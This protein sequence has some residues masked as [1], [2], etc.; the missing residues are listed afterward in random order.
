[1]NKLPMSEIQRT[2][3][4]SERKIEQPQDLFP[5][6]PPVRKENNEVKHFE[7][8]ERQTQTSGS[9]LGAFAN[10]SNLFLDRHALRIGRTAGWTD[11]GW[12]GSS[13]GGSLVGHALLAGFFFGVAGAG[14]D[15]GVEDVAA[16]AGETLEVVDDVCRGQVGGC[17]AGFGLGALLLPA[18]IEQLD[19][20]VLVEFGHG[21]LLVAVGAEGCWAGLVE[22]AGLRARH[23]VGAD[24][25]R[26]LAWGG[27][28]GGLGC[29]GLVAGLGAFADA[30][31]FFLLGGVGGRSGGDRL[32][33]VRCNH[34]RY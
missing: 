9:L 25:H 31:L 13:A 23:V 2:P 16:L 10:V 22:T 21:D 17:A 18:G 7:L 11:H 34:W 12:R 30:L 15:G 8:E 33:W 20:H 26:L 6:E 32:L 14:E 29:G 4:K 1:M 19:S 24:T 27:F 3:M 28:G 5:D